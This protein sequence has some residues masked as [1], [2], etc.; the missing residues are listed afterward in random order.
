MLYYSFHIMAGL[1]TI[2][3]GIMA[4]SAVLLWTGR[5]ERTWPMLWVLMMSFPFPYIAVT[6]GG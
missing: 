5:L 2:L 3:I 6:A 1:G 4:L